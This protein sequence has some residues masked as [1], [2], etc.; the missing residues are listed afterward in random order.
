MLASTLEIFNK[1]GSKLVPYRF[2]TVMHPTFVAANLWLG[3]QR[4]C[5][6]EGYFA[7]IP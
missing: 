2:R 1:S 5:Q 6:F 3:K 4:Q 7:I